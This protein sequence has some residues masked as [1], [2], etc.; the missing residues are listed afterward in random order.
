MA[1]LTRYDALAYSVPF[2]AGVGFLA[3]RAHNNPPGR[4][5][6]LMIVTGL[7]IAFTVCGWFLVY[8]LAAGDPLHFAQGTLAWHQGFIL[9]VPLG[10]IVAGWIVSQLST[11][12]A[13]R[14]TV[15]CARCAL[16]VAVTAA[17]VGSGFVEARS[18]QDSQWTRP[19]T[20]G[21]INLHT[22]GGVEGWIID[23]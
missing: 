4:V 13:R 10:I 1:S 12:A 22:G 15:I 20:V 19:H 18:L 21:E 9:T 3:R 16:L 8:L 14:H 7:P 5:Q 2:L 11:M 17:T 23:E 6:A